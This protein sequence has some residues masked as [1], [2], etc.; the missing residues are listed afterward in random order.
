V[1]CA[2]N[3][4]VIFA[5]SCGCEEIFAAIG[6]IAVGV[7]DL[8]VVDVGVDVGVV[9]L[10]VVEPD[11]VEPDVVGV[12]EAVEAPV[13]IGFPLVV[14]LAP[15]ERAATP[16]GCATAGVIVRQ[17]QTAPPAT[18]RKSRIRIPP[19]RRRARRVPSLLR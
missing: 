13:V 11:V 9:D 18:V 12:P 19:G 15:W 6:F 17:V 3:S 1:V 7:V 4:A 16:C 14:G 8:D 5:F 2:G 10:D